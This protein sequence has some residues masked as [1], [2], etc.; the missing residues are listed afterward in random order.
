MSSDHGRTWLL[1]AGE[2]IEGEYATDP[3]SQTSFTNH[4]AP[5]VLIDYNSNIYRIGGRERVNGA[6][7]YYSDV[8]V[9][10]NAIKWTDLAESS[11]APYDSERFYAGAIATSKGE[12]ILQG[13]TVNNFAEYKS[14]VWSSTNGRNWRLQTA[15]AEFGTRGIGV[16]LQSQHNDRLSGKDILYLLGGQNE[17]DNNNE[18]QHATLISQPPTLTAAFTISCDLQMYCVFCIVLC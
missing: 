3:A 2:T 12:I 18:G 13:G 8:W 7:S 17:K 10:T 6:D 1:A 14:D 9:S 4:L 5:A 11:T 15:E 16:L